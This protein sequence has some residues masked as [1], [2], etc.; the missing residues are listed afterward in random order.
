MSKV[1]DIM[2]NS[3][4]DELAKI[5]GEMQGF[6]RVG[7]KPIG[8]ER[9]LEKERESE[10]TPSTVFKQNVEKVSSVGKALAVMGL[11]SG[12]T[13]LAQRANKDRELGRQVRIQQ[14]G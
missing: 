6:T 3:F 7:V 5:A 10:E 4:R 9:L 12:L 11:G 8:V 13:L 1:H 14:G 2:R